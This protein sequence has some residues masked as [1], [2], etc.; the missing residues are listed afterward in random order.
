MTLSDLLTAMV[1]L[2]ASDLH[3]KPGQPPAMRV[4]G[5][6][7][8]VKGEAVEEDEL[9][10]WFD[11]WLT[12]R[13]E[14]DLERRG[15][16]DLSI[17]TSDGSRFRCNLFRQLG[18]LAAVLRR[19]NPAPPSIAAL[20]LPE[21]LERVVSLEQG[22]ILIAGA[23]GSGKS[24]TLAALIDAINH[25]RRCHVITIE[26]PVEYIFIEDRALVSQ[27]EVG[28]DV[29]D[30]GEGLRAALREDP[31]VLLLG[32]LRD[33]ETCETAL[34]AAETGHLVFATVHAPG[35]PQTINR[36]MDLFPVAR[37]AQIRNALAFSLKLVA[38]QRLLPAVSGGLVPAVELL[39]SSPLVRKLI[40]DGEFAR[41]PEALIKDAESGSEAV[42]RALA[43]LQ[44]A[45]TVSTEAAMAAAPNPEELRM[46]LR[47]I[48]VSQ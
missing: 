48:T 8:R 2:D 22:L 5:E 26:D 33:A 44:R 17:A 29:P 19:V 45:G 14:G 6:L 20:S 9:R 25:R 21:Q 35:A 3:L 10:A 30:F 39:F 47:G 12:P 11:P 37:H 13:H 46:V 1:R 7:G 27:R 40:G 42:V 23:T 4:H 36:I 28:V 16:C 32:E 18:R 31:D 24:T 43:R 41:L 34:H 15:S 38:H